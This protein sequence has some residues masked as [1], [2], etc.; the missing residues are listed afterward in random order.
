MPHGPA[1]VL[2]QHLRE[3]QVKKRMGKRLGQEE[4]S[5]LHVALSDHSSVV[6]Q[7]GCLLRCELMSRLKE[8]RMASRRERNEGRRE[9][10]REGQESF[11]S[12]LSQRDGK[13]PLV[14]QDRH[15]LGVRS[16]KSDFN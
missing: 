15:C 16:L 7:G 14:A 5:A 3:G 2:I 10:G 13:R 9:E 8:E 6:C 1:K 11:S 12:P 4:G